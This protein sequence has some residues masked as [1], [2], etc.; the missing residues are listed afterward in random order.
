MS[1]LLQAGT[2]FSVDGTTY[3]NPGVPTLLQ[4]M[5]GAKTAKELL[6][7]GRYIGLP[8]NSVIELSLPGGVAGGGHP[9]HLHGVSSPYKLVYIS[10]EYTDEFDP[11]YF[12]CHSKCRK[13]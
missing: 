9:L 4:L 11:A 6:P 2:L 8:S 13:H 5:S 1:H 3:D 12:P 10:I 7:S